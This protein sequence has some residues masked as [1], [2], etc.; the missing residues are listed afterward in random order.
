M[1]SF[2]SIISGDFLGSDELGFYLYP[3]FADGEGEPM[4][5]TGVHQHLPVFLAAVSVT[6]LTRLKFFFSLLQPPEETLQCT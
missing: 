4:Y 1:T 5:T 6:Y 2:R 3:V